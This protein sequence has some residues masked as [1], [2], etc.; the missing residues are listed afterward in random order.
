M[1]A[2]LTALSVRAETV[3]D[4]PITKARLQRLTIAMSDQAQ[5]P[6]FREL[7]SNHVQAL[8]QQ[9]EL[10]AVDQQ[11]TQMKREL[12]RLAQEYSELDDLE[13]RVKFAE[14][15]FNSAIGKIDVGKSNIFSSYPLVQQLMRPTLP[16]TRDR[17]RLLFALL[18]G[19]AS[20]VFVSTG[21]TLA[22]L[23]RKTP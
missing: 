23:R 14:A 2:T 22:W 12:D 5:E 9:N 7:V 15:V 19:L 21:L 20:S 13:R 17:R 18:G 1:D 4:A 3:L 6:L 11:L 8:A 16:Q 10:S